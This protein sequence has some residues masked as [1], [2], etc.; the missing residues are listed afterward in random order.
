M[1]AI[2]NRVPARAPLGRRFVALLID[3]TLALLLNLLPLLGSLVALGYILTRDHIVFA[4]LGN[5]EY[6]DRSVGK[7]VAGLR[8]VNL[9]PGGQM[10][11]MLA[12]K[13]NSTLALGPLLVLVMVPLLGIGVAIISY[14]ARVGAEATAT[15][16]VLIWM[17]LLLLA[18]LSVV[19]ALVEAA[20]VLINPSGRR[21]GD[22]LANTQVVEDG[23]ASAGSG[24]AAGNG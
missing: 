13:R 9:A 1:E 15:I 12:V 6:R 23:P 16:G 14:I 20:M 19:P 10:T 5:E 17:V 7:K 4:L 11:L 2:Q 24:T 18:L 22:R 21:L 3:V 8:V